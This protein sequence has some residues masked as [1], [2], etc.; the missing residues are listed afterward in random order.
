MKDVWAGK[1]SGM[2]TSQAKSV[3]WSTIQ[4]IY[5]NKATGLQGMGDD[6]PADSSS[7]LTALA[8][9]GLTAAS[10][11]LAAKQQA[12]ANTSVNAA[13]PSIMTVAPST[14]SKLPYILGGLVAVGVLFMILRKKKTAPS[15]PAA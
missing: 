1:Q 8:S 10:Q 4:K 15:T 6:A 3:L 2:T 14:S 12:A 5:G 11:L 13:L 7:D 9:Q